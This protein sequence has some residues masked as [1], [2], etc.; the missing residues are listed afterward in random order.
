VLAA[1]VYG[2]SDDWTRAEALLKKAIELD[3]SSLDAYGLLGQLYA[4]Q[5]R[6]D[7]ARSMFEEIVKKRPGSVAAHTVVGLIHEA[8]GHTAEAQ[9]WYERV[10]GIDPSAAV[11]CN[12][13]AY[14]YAEHGGNLDVALK[15]AQRARER[16]PDSPQVTDTIGWVYYRKRLFTAAIPLFERAVALAPK[17]PTYRLHLALTYRDA[18]EAAKAREAF[19][20]VLA[21][22]PES[23]EATEARKALG[24]M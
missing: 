6:L 23:P 24:V 18:G 16:L 12:N 2:A 19:S 7:S 13:L 20:Q 3:P 8:Q 1:R 14:I 15:L 4:S 11:A 10:L 17:N 22:G 9:K 5:N 21:V